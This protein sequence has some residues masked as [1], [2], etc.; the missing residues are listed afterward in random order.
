MN[1]SNKDIGS[2]GEDLAC[3]YL[4]DIKHKIL[5]RNFRSK[6]GEIDIITL[7]NNM[8]I[9]TEV[10]SRY[11]NSY[12]SPMESV[13]YYKQRQI[14]KLSS[15][16]I[17]INKFNNCNIRYDV[18]EILFNKSNQNFTINHIKDAFRSY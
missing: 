11:T 10:K 6:L 2:Y 18:I 8:I 16:Y 9:F 15:Y 3:K 12:G 14:I 7:F 1:V 13:T 5:A 17:L 4:L